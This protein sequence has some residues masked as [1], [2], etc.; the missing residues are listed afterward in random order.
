MTLYAACLEH[1]L[2]TLMSCRTLWSRFADKPP[3]TKIA[4]QFRRP[5]DMERITVSEQQ[6]IEPVDSR[7]EQILTNHPLIIPLA[8]AIEQ[9]FRASRP[10]MDGRAS[11][12]IQHCHVRTGIF[13]PVRPVDVKVPAGNLRE[14]LHD[15]ENK[16]R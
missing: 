10:H 15:P 13:G 12:D 5:A 6:T 11:A 3:P 16:P 4:Q 7:P 2:Q 14:Q 9:P 1:A 8:P